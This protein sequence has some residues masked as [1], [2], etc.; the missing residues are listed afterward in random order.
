MLQQISI[1][2]NFHFVRCLVLVVQNVMLGNSMFVFHKNSHSEPILG[3][4][5][6]FLMFEFERLPLFVNDFFIDSSRYCCWIGKCQKG[7]KDQKNWNG[8][9]HCGK[10]G[11]RMNTNSLVGL[12]K[13][14]FYHTWWE[15]WE[16]GE[17]LMILLYSFVILFF[18]FLRNSYHTFFLVLISICLTS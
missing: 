3:Q 7:Q 16:T 18:V 6:G 4:I 2:I 9:L 17:Y 10:S 13:W 14:N 11:M 12:Y 1:L 5:I 8:D 15:W